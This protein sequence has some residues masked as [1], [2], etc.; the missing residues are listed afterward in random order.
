MVGIG[1]EGAVMVGEE[2]GEETTGRNLTGKDGLLI[3]IYVDTL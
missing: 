2:D 1:R 3:C